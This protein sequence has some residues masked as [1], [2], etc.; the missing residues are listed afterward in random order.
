M[1]ILVTGK[2]GQVG[3]ELQRSLAPL[4]E[5][6][7]VDQAECNL[8]DPD[9]IRSLIRAFRPQIIVNPAAYTAVDKAESEPEAAYAVNTRAPE[10]MG[11]EAARLGALVV[12][13]CT[14]YVYDGQKAGFYTEQDSPHPL[15]VYG[16]TKA[17]GTA[18]LCR[19][20]DKHLVFRTSWVFGAHGH[21]FAK[22]ILRLARERDE[23]KVV[24]DQ[25]GAP[26]SA[27]LLADI[28]AQVVGQYLRQADKQ[29]FPY[30]LYHCTA[31]GET[32]WCDFA[33]AVVAFALHNG[34]DL[35]VRLDKILPI[36]TADYPLP[37]RRPTNSR[38]STEALQQ[39]FGLRPPPWQNGLEHVL[40]QILGV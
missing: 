38:F 18:A 6:Y 9:A 11:E 13:Y 23:L 27:A 37:A 30:G 28:A 36:T 34:V 19:R 33:K 12:H 4:G 1:R 10:V 39:T 29:A 8:A 20:T 17:E 24:A 15:S 32:T 14:D 35:K 31:G 16:K 40:Q 7:A 21:N 26:T 5:V 3:F 22:T 2:N 25:Y